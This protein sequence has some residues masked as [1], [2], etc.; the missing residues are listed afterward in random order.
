[1]MRSTED[2]DASTVLTAV[3]DEELSTIVEELDAVEF[4][5]NLH[6]VQPISGHKLV[7]LRFDLFDSCA[8]YKF[9]SFI[10][11]TPFCLDRLHRQ[12]VST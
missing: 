3:K 5:Q 8:R 4:E 1:M 7:L 9:S 6:A 12:G 10:Q 11:E 2:D